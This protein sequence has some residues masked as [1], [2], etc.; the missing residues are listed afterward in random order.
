[1]NDIST[2]KQ[3]QGFDFAGRWR[4]RVH[5]IGGKKDYII[6]ICVNFPYTGDLRPPCWATQG[7]H[8]VF[9][10]VAS[11][12]P[13]WYPYGPV[14]SNGRSAG[15][16]ANL[17]CLYFFF[18][19]TPNHMP[20]TAVSIAAVLLQLQ[21]FWYLMCTVLTS[22]RRVAWCPELRRTRITTGWLW[23]ATS[24]TVISSIQDSRSYTTGWCRRDN[25][26][27]HAQ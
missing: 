26:A 20:C 17:S 22:W 13:L 8:I 9:I 7:P 2:W 24:T 3:Q 11:E 10:V 27:T 15:R 6:S 1:M 4:P 19:S 14:I 12:T 16:T 25:N 5:T 18:I 23:F 21:R